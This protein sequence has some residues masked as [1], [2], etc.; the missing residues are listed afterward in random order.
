M[1]RVNDINNWY[2]I[3]VMTG[4]EDT[5]SRIINTNFKEECKAFVQKRLMRE[6]RNGTWTNRLRTLFPG[7]VFLNGRI[8]SIQYSKLKNVPG[9]IRLFQDDYRPI[10]INEED[11]YLINKLMQNGD[12]IGTSH[13]LVNGHKV[14][15]I[16]GPLLGLEGHIN[17]VDKRKK[18]ARVQLNFMGEPRTVD[19]C[20]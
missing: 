16:S 18:R 12:I 8:T 19:L 1:I 5:I 11:I 14:A 6:R 4:K 7:Y 13:L 15:V 9:V 10:R 2:V 17:K 3:F 20:I